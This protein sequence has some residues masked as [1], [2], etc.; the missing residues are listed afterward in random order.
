MYS[1][2]V[3]GLVPGTDVQITFQ[4][5]LA[6]MGVLAGLS[7]LVR[8][9]WR[10]WRRGRRITE[11]VLESQAAMLMVVEPSMELPRPLHPAV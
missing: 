2:L 6:A 1:L 10:W 7:L 9:S 8:A 11:S 5:W 4:M 3:L